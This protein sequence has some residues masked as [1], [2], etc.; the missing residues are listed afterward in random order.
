LTCWSPTDVRLSPV[1]PL[2]QLGGDHAKVA[3]P[4]WDYQ[5]GAGRDVNAL[6]AALWARRAK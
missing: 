4:W 2:G 5:L 1:S 3:D 6:L